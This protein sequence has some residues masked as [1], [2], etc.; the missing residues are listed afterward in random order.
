MRGCLKEAMYLF[1]SEALFE[2]IVLSAIS[3]FIFICVPLCPCV[4][5]S[6]LNLLLNLSNSVFLASLFKFKVSQSKV[7]RRRKKENTEQRRKKG[8]ERREKREKGSE[9][10]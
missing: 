3:F 1:P 10:E 6:F 9:K 7:Q 5:F 2:K 8:E 4:Y